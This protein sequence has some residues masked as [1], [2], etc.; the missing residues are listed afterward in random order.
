MIQITRK[1]SGKRD[2][3]LRAIQ[4][5]KSHPSARQ[6][7]ESLKTAVPGLSLGTVYRN[8][9]I[10]RQE[11]KVVSVGVV[12]CEERFDGRVD[13]HPHFICECCGAVLDLG[14][15]IQSEIN[16]KLSIDIPECTIDKQ[17][18]VFYGLCKDCTENKAG[19]SL[20]RENTAL[21]R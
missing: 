3:I 9:D 2:A 7:H 18:V 5:T 8:I 11:G 4:S 12:D 16:T 13:S 14:E 15:E 6:I 21:G 19:I 1:H 17:K 10:F 20:N